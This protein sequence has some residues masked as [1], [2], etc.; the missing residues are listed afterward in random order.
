MEE[1]NNIWENDVLERKQFATQWSNI[2][3]VQT[4]PF[5]LNINGEWGTGKTFLAENW[6]KQLRN[7]GEVA[8]YYNAWECDTYDDPFITLFS[9]I[10]T[11][12]YESLPDHEQIINNISKKAS[13]I[14][15]SLGRLALD[16]SVRK[17]LGLSIADINDSFQ[18]SENVNRIK[19]YE[20]YKKNKKVFYE[21]LNDLVSKLNIKEKNKKVY[22]FIDE[23]DRCSPRFAIQ[24]LEVVKHLFNIPLFVFIILTDN[25]QLNEAIRG[26]YGSGFNA[27]KYLNRF[28]NMEISLPTPNYRQFIAKLAKEGIFDIR[29]IRVNPSWPGFLVDIS[30]YFSKEFSFS[31][32]DIEHFIRYIGYFLSGIEESSDIEIIEFAV[33]LYWAKLKYPKEYNAANYKKNLMDLYKLFSK[34][35]LTETTK[36]LNYYNDVIKYYCKFCS[37]EDLIGIPISE[38]KL[39]MIKKLSKSQY[40]DIVNYIS[41]IVRPKSL[42]L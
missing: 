5:V 20:D 19:L 28:F 39:N 34:N 3:K 9:E 21:E 27:E 16:A 14:I 17:L 18:C 12:L 7:D 2:L 8:V 33:F 36:H 15:P 11:V 1:I 30:E 22:V 6:F 41:S 42:Y 13:F 35:V 24:L 26:Y 38:I 31:L 25:S 37:N 10:K 40:W 23:L 4:E 29:V 32:R